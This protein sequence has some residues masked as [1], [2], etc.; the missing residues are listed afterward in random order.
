M[1]G[2]G[3]GGGHAWAGGGGFSPSSSP[4]MHCDRYTAGITCLMLIETAVFIS[5]AAT[6]KTGEAR[7]ECTDPDNPDTCSTFRTCQDAYLIALLVILVVTGYLCCF[8]GR[9]RK[10][11]NYES[12]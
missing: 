6:C 5:L 11:R 3:H 10:R 4:D 1:V 12:V 2:G 9:C 7:Q 8:V